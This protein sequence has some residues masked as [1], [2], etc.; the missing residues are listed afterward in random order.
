LRRSR[1]EIENVRHQN[2][3]LREAAEPLIHLAAAR[4]RF[5]FIHA[6]RERFSVKLMCRVLIADRS[7]YHGWVR[8]LDRRRDS[9][10]TD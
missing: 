8:A 6:R 4:E 9:E 1:R 2:E 10:H 5:A 7:N 3:V